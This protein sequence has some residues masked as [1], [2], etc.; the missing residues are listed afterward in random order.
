MRMTKSLRMSEADSWPS[1][2]SFTDHERG[3]LRSGTCRRET[4]MKRLGFS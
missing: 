1:P 3:R 4:M 2:T